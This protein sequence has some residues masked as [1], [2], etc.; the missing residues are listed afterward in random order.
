MEKC[1]E[2]EHQ[3][4]QVINPFLHPLHVKKPQSVLDF[5]AFKN[6]VCNSPAEKM[7]AVGFNLFQT[8][9]R[10]PIYVPKG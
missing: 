3:T 10:Y 6:K 5:N 2:L 7:F 9:P 4:F 1:L 8:D